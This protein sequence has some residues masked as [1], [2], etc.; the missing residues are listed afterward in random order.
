[1]TYPIEEIPGECFT[2]HFVNKIEYQNDIL[3]PNVFANNRGGLSG[4]WDKYATAKD[5]RN[6]VKRFNRNPNDFGVISLCAKSV[7]AIHLQ[8]VDHDPNK[9]NQAHTEIRGDKPE[10]ILL[11]F[12]D[13]YEWEIEID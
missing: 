1:M 9:H 6:R 4:D 13:I 10:K 7:R 11:E 5:T 8:T 2:F 12:L 3:N